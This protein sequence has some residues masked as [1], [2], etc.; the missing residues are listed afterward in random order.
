VLARGATALILDRSAAIASQREAAAAKRV[1]RGLARGVPYIGGMS[2]G[3]EHAT[4]VDQCPRAIPAWLLSLACHLV[5]LVLGAWLVGKS[6]PVKGIVEA[7]RPAGIV[8]V[9]RT[10]GKAEYFSDE[11]LPA[12]QAADAVA[13]TSTSSGG[14]IAA[15]GLPTSQPPP[16]VTGLSLPKLSGAVTGGEGLV[17]SPQ[18][19]SGR[20]RPAILPGLD[21][22]AIRAADAGVPQE[23]VPTGPTAQMSLFGSGSAVGR[24]FVFVIDRSQSMGGEGLGAISAA[25]KELTEQLEQLSPEQRFQV[26]AYNQSVTMIEGRELLPADGK[27][28]DRLIRFVADTAAYGQT[29]H[30]RGL[31]AALKLKPEVIFLLTDGGEPVLD[32]SQLRAIREQAAGKTSIHCLQFGRGPAP[33]AGSFL[34]R[35]A[36]ENGGSYVYIDMNRRK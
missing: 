14:R 5:V 17:A 22:A 15:E 36:A 19:G 34:E 31:L 8:L 1:F 21:D 9:Q 20:G 24:S 23:L 4:T 25:A 7:D 27:N 11:A 33:D 13:A 2:R 32:N 16:L 28:K 12:A 29:E 35:L 6:E 3:L 30:M 26:V 10:T 18:P